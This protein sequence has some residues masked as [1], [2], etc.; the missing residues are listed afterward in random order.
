MGVAKSFG[1]TLAVAHADLTLGTGTVTTLEGANGSGKSTL[2]L[3]L[4]LLLRPTRGQVL[5]DEKPAGPAWHA[6]GRIGLVAHFPAAYLDLTARENLTLI[7]KLHGISDAY[8]KI[9]AL[10]ER[11]AIT[12]FADRPMRT[13]SRGQ[14]Q[15]V[16]LARSILPAPRL[17]LL[18]EP[19][20][21]LDGQGLDELELA[22]IEERE[23]G[24]II[25]L[26]THDR[27]WARKIADHRVRLDNGKV[28]EMES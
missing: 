18:D 8:T 14:Q 22:L 1:G 10:V 23:R 25:A 9:E 5:F 11:F 12:E 19:T 28:M 3:L 6:R 4:A 24:A 20:T 26:A 27:V 13:Y 21:G 16:A 17:L 2:L 15:R 7:A